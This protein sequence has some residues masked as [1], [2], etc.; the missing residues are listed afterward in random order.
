MIIIDFRIIINF[1]SKINDTN[2]LMSLLNII[3]IINMDDDEKISIL[4]KIEIV[5]S[6]KIWGDP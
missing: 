3:Y 5:N 6:D 4:S 2:I 1:V